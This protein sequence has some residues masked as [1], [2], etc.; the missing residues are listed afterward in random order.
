MTC[1]CFFYRVSLLS[2]FVP[3]PNGLNGLYMGVILTTV[4][5]RWGDPPSR[6]PG[7]PAENG[8]GT[9]RLC[10]SEV[11]GHPNHQLRI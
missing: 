2:G 5:T 3:L 8:S 9:Q 1:K 4:L 6:D 11:I 10:I 7:S